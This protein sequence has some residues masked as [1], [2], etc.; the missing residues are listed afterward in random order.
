MSTLS[1]SILL[2]EEQQQIFNYIDDH[3]IY[4]CTNEEQIKLGEYKKSLVT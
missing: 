2:D 3:K 4:G 1:I